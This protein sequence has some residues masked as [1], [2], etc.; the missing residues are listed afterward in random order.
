M[1]F[2]DP[3]P[4]IIINLCYPV[5]I[6]KDKDQVI[7]FEETYPLSSHGSRPDFKE[8]GSVHDFKGYWSN[9]YFKGFV[10]SHDFK[11]SGS[12]EDFKVYPAM[13]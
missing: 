2:K 11:E 5:M 10:S 13:N 8:Y 4:W 1:I 6:L 7:T 9:Y 12:I 3:D